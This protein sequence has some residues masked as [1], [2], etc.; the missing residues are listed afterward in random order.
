MAYG[1]LGDG[2][3]DILADWGKEQ[4]LGRGAVGK[5]ASYIVY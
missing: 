4:L 2:A 5:P 1:Q 3:A